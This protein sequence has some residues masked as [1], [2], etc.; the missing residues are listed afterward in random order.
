MRGK[1]FYMNVTCHMNNDHIC[2]FCDDEKQPVVGCVQY[3]TS[4]SQGKKGTLFHYCARC[5]LQQAEK[6]ARVVHPNYRVQ[7]I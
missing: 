2:D 6:M 5:V 1:I 4:D 3:E 7:K